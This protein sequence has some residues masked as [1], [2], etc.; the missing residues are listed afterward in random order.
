MSSD[1]FSEKMTDIVFNYLSNKIL[2]DDEQAETWGQTLFNYPRDLAMRW[3]KDSLK[4]KLLSNETVKRLLNVSEK[5]LKL[6]T[7]ES[8]DN[9][10]EE[11]DQSLG[12]NEPDTIKMVKYL[13][14]L[15]NSAVINY[16]KRAGLDFD[17]QYDTKSVIQSLMTLMGQINHIGGDI[18][19]ELAEEDDYT[20]NEYSDD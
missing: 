12:V 7:D 5:L 18:R 20:E 2:K 17:L 15:V 4:N 14:K 9:L 13:L 3:V 19:E 8:L 1:P 16:F 10:S 11:V 6:S